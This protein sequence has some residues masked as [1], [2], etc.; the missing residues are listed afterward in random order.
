MEILFLTVTLINALKT[1]REFMK[2]CYLLG[3]VRTCLSAGENS[4]DEKLDAEHKKVYR[5]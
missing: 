5:R 1:F 2:T 4:D 3:A